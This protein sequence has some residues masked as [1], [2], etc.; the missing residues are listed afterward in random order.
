MDEA[1]DEALATD[2][3]D[4]EADAVS[5]VAGS[6]A[7]ALSLPRSQ[8]PLVNW[9]VLRR[10]EWNLDDEDDED[11][12]GVAAAASR[13]VSSLLEVA[14][15]VAALLASSFESF[16]S[17]ESLCDEDLSSDDDTTIDLGRFDMVARVRECV[18]GP[19]SRVCAREGQQQ[20]TTRDQH[21]SLGCRS[22]HTHHTMS[23]KHRPPPVLGGLQFTGHVP[24]FLRAYKDGSGSIVGGDAK[25]ERIASLMKSEGAAH[26]DEIH[27]DDDMQTIVEKIR[28]A[29]GTVVGTHGR[30]GSSV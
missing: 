18:R 8:A 22:S 25:Q 6:S 27:D 13:A 20:T 1:D 7:K 16:E 19:P 21:H 3:A 5:G 2:D 23:K 14:A 28:A 11:L 29:G 17:F 30:A 9:L 24:K 12:V 15:T 4:D 26:V 10:S